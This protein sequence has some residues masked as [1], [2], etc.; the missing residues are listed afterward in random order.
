M[1]L[2]S[3]AFSWITGIG[4][5]PVDQINIEELETKL[6]AT[7]H[8]R[9]S[10]ERE[11]TAAETEY[12]KIVS[13]EENSRR[14]ALARKI[15]FQKGAILA[16][17]IKTLT[18]AVAMLSRLGGAID[19]LKDLKQFYIDLTKTSALPKGL[20]VEDTLKQ[21]YAMSDAMT[22]K[23][24][25]LDE[26]QTVLDETQKA[27][28]PEEEEEDGINTV[29]QE[30]NALYDQYNEKLALNDTAGADAIKQQI[31]EKQAEMDKQI[32]METLS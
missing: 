15:A 20:S 16:K 3:E 6:R 7:E 14:S 25:D 31:D 13:V 12:R 27:V 8:L 28:E 24:K 2:M 5:K 29:M 30:L 18:S 22:V 32:G 17:K 9:A 26:M 4:K 10:W 19:Q 1:G 23:L 11:V 21:I